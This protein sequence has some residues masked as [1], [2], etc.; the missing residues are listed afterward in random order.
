MRKIS[1]AAKHDSSMTYDGFPLDLAELKKSNVLVSGTN[2][3]GKSRASMF[4]ADIAMR[5]NWQIVVFDNVG[6][7]K[8]KSSIPIFYEVSE[9]SMSY[10]LT[11][12][13]IIYDISLL[14]PSYQKE[15]VEN[16]L[17]DLWKMKLENPNGKW[18][19]VIFEDSSY[20]LRTLE[21][22]FHRTF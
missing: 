8:H 5:E 17:A 6:I 10:V 2:Q 22:T 1:N 4:L 3:Q 12:Q 15:F 19:L 9:V 11:E 7:W 13:S 20:T 18:L 21:V 14:L 16:V